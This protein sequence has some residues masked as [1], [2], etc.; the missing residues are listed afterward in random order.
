MWKIIKRYYL[1]SFIGFLILF[2]IQ[3]IGI[4]S[5]NTPLENFL[6]VLVGA[7]VLSAIIGTLYYF[8]DTK[9]G[10]KKRE[11]RFSKTPL[12]QLLESGFKREGDF[13][14]GTVEGYTVIVVY[15]WPGG[16][17]AI[18][19]DVLFDPRFLGGFHSPADIKQI[20]K[21]NK[22]SSTWTNNNYLWTLN[23]IG[24]QLEYT[25][26]PPSA[27]KVITRTKELVDILV[28]ENL[29]PITLEQTEEVAKNNRSTEGLSIS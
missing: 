14:T 13:V 11:K 29:K 28:K 5:P 16:K 24:L 15:V 3:G 7:F 25:F 19:I 17:S 8:Q 10:P 4:K 18:N 21:R 2:A 6:I 12:K 1:F 22:K 26:T 23:S 20:E 9:W 27:E